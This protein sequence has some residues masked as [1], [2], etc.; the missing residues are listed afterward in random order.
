MFY[1]NQTT[2]SPLAFYNELTVFGEQRQGSLITLPQVFYRYINILF[3]VSAKTITYWAAIAEF[4]S[5]VLII[6]LLIYGYIKKMRPSYLLFGVMSLVLPSLTGSFSSL[7]RYSLLIFPIFISL[8]IF[9]STKKLA[10]KAFFYLFL[11][12]LLIIE[13]S[14]FLRGYWVA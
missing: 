3:T 4:I 7:P 8:G 6:V 13:T 2:G 10:I 9:L 14:L 12:L 11:G 1:L 5:A